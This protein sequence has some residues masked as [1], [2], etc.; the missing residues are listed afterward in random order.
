MNA[1]TPE[2]IIETA[3][4][5]QRARIVMTAFELDLFTILGSRRLSSTAVARLSGTDARAVD[6]L[7]N[8][9]VALDVLEKRDGRFAN[10]KLSG[11]Y[12]DRAGR[13]YVARLGHTINMMTNWNRLTKAVKK[14]G[15]VGVKKFQNRGGAWFEPFIAA[16]HDRA[17]DEAKEIAAAV[18]VKGGK[19]LDIG[20]GSGAHAMEFVRRGA[21][22]AT[23]F[24]LPEVIRLTRAYVKAAGMKQRISFIEGDFLKDDPG[25]G[26]DFIFISAI[27]HMLDPKRIKILLKRAVAALA[28]GG[29]VAIQDFFMNDERTEP[30]RGA[31]FALTMLVGTLHGDTY[32]DRETRAWM[33]AAGLK[34]IK[35]IETASDAPLLV[36][37]KPMG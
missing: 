26:Y 23:V 2:K 11:R 8:A 9:L 32:T 13:D 30:R 22:S 27:I 17:V 33:T 34:Q 36:G 28:P 10:T 3:M 29:R 4:E 37:H 25:S 5:Y 31:L 6:R 19:V 35:R 15:A 20:G 21:R 24:D 7:L 12:Y 14:G 16:M 1:F 18:S